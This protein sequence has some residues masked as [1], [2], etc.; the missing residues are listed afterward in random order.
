M[1]LFK[2]LRAKLLAEKQQA[3]YQSKLNQLKILYPVQ[4]V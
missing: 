1:P 4:R 2:Q 3:A